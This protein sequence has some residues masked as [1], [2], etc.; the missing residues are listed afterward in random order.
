MATSQ[1]TT[2]NLRAI[3]KQWTGENP[4]AVGTQWMGK[5][6]MAIGTQQI[7]V[8]LRTV[9]THS[10]APASIETIGRTDTMRPD[11]DHEKSA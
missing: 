7:G 5:N 10:H 6:P 4:R 8:N 1:Q 11:T 2:I 9:A 3:G